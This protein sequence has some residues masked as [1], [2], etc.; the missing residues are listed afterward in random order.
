M[1]FEWKIVVGIAPVFGLV[2]VS[3]K[4]VLGDV[5]VLLCASALLL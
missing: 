3:N 4:C 5:E 2:H 1:E